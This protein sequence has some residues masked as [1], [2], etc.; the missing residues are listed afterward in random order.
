MSKCSTRV[1]LRGIYAIAFAFGMQTLLTAAMA[2]N[3]NGLFQESSDEP[4]MATHD[5]AGEVHFALSIA[6]K[7]A[8][9][10]TRPSDIVVYVDTS[11][12]QAGVFK[13]DSIEL[14]K[15]LLKGLNAEDRV[16]ILAVDLDPISLTNGFVGPGS[17]EARVALSNLNERV[18]LG[19]TDV[20]A[21]LQAAAKAFPEDSKR[22]RNV[23]YV[24]DAISRGELLHADVFETLVSQLADNQVTFSSFAIGPERNIELLAALANNTGG[25]FVIDSDAENSVRNGAELLAKTIRGSVFWPTSGKLDESIIDLFPYRFPPLRSD[26]DTIVMGTL[27]DREAV[28]IEMTGSLEGQDSA[29][30]WSITPEASS[31]DFAFLPSVVRDARKDKGYSLPT[32]GSEGLREYVR[33]R[34][35][36][37]YEL[38]ELG[39]QALAIGNKEAARKLAGA[40]LNSDPT[41]TNADIL[42]MAATYKVNQEDDP[43]GTAPAA[44]GTPTQEPADPFGGG[45]APAA[46]P[47]G[48][49]APAADPFGG[50]AP[51]ADPFGAAEAPVEMKKEPE[52]SDIVIEP[53]QQQPLA[54]EAAP[55]DEIATPE[56]DNGLIMIDPGFQDGEADQLLR[57]ARMGQSKD[58]IVSEEDRIR[59]INQKTRQLVQFEL[60][61]GRGELADNPDSAI[62]RIKNVIEIVDQ[63]PDLYESTRAELRHSLES[64]LLSFRQRKLDYDNIVAMENINISTADQI[65]AAA[66]GLARKN[67]EVNRLID[68]FNLLVAEGNYQTARDVTRRAAEIAPENPDVVAAVET[69]RVAQNYNQLV[70]LRRQKAENFASALYNIEQSTV[71]FPGEPLMVFPDADEWK[72]KV[73][74]RK[75]FKNFRLAGS[76]IDE[77]ILEAL[78]QPA[79]MNYE[80]TSWTEVEE[81]L[82]AKYKINIVLTASARDDSLTEDE[83]ITANFNGIRFKNALRLLLAEKNATYVVKDEVLMIISIDDKY[84]EQYAAPPNVYNVGDLVAPRRNNNQGGGFGGGGGGFGGG[85]GGFGGGQ[86]GGGFGGGQGGGAGGLFCVQESKVSLNMSSAASEKAA[87]KKPTMLEPTVSWKDYFST[88]FADPADVRYT[89]KKLVNAGKAG[90]A[91][92]MIHGAIQN[93]QLQSWMYEGLVLTMRISGAPQSEIERAL[94]SAV[95]LSDNEEDTL[96]AANYMLNNDMEAR[97]IRL[98]KSFARSNP[99]RTEPFV[100]GLRAAQRIDDIEGIKWATLGIFGQEWPDHPEIVKQAQFASTAIKNRMKKAGQLEALATYEKDLLAAQERDCFINVSWT[101]DADLDLYVVEPGG[102]ICSRLARRTSS[103]GV[104]MGD[105]FS[106]KQGQSGIISEQYVLPKGFAGSYRLMIKRVWGEVTGGKVNVSIHTHYRSEKERSMTKQVNIDDK[107]ALVLFALDQGRRTESLEDHEIRTAVKRQLVT[108]RTLLAQQIEESSSYGAESDYYGSLA[109]ANLGGPGAGLGGGINPR[110]GNLRPGLA[111]YQPVITQLFEG[112]QFFVNHATTADRLY[113]I[114]SVSPNFTQVT[115]VATFNIF[116]DAETAQNLANNGGGGAGGGGG[117]AGGGGGGGGIF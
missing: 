36:K 114:V 92:E 94:M 101:G 52:A 17:E 7:A 35:A 74:R 87:P 68:S 98:L 1:A 110:N 2:G 89:A 106:K 43:F 97:A 16:Q 41:N 96:Y 9:Q 3:H 103:G 57:D 83:P 50:D 21:M 20:E 70:D 12:S 58:L 15:Q 61:T 112:T 71:P 104:S 93:D 32:V 82:E 117:G 40:A 109:G 102:T 44:G 24:G 48:G 46:D 107:G 38:T 105:H 67:E 81:E 8:P 55:A 108:N 78:E 76:K 49:D 72:R 22:N 100:L 90:Q 37:A 26:R 4:R 33:A 60:R 85:Q 34:S 64:A 75:R 73:I 53:N 5:V 113:V 31:A 25:N 28:E 54:V 65:S 19:S 30:T 115:E 18:S 88:N 6:P 62:E 66:D 95:D 63:T 39:G 80:D 27:T 42:S 11:A 86:G 84:A 45:D 51:A 59:I 29:M 111:G 79:E 77:A 116:G 56:P 91:V 69:A 47:F 14:V 99:A 13:R 23:I 10:A